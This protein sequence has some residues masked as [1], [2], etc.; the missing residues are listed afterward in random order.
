MNL[1]VW[2]SKAVL[3][4]KLEARNERNP[5]Q[6]W[7]L[8]KWPSCLSAPGEH[9]LFVASSGAW[10]GYFILSKDALLNPDDSTT[11]FTLLFD[12]PD[13]DVDNTSPRQAFPWF[14]LQGARA[15]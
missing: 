8:S 14:Y 15:G 3:S 7:N 4:H 11:P 5:E 13:V 1:G 6:A 9:R 2:M 10:R 12:T